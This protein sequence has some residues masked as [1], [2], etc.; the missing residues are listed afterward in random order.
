MSYKF[1]GAP[2]F[3]PN[4]AE[5]V[6][7]I[8]KLILQKAVRA[9]AHPADF[10]EF[11]MREQTTTRR[12]KCAPHQRIGL[13]F[14]LDH[15]KCVMVWPAGAAKTM[16]V[17]ALILWMLG[18][19][20]TK[21]GAIVSKTQDQA[22]KI[23]GVIQQYI[24]KSSELRLVFPHLRRSAN[25]SWREDRIVVDRPGAIPDASVLAIGVDGSIQGSR[26]DWMVFDDILDK[27][28]TRTHEARQK[29][30]DDVLALVPRIEA[31]GRMIVN[32][33][34]WHPEDAVHFL[35][36]PRKG[37]LPSLR[38]TITGDIY[39]SDDPER[40]RQGLQP[41]DHDLLRPK[42]SSGADYACRIKRDVPDL[43]NDI[44]LFPERF[45]YCD[46]VMADGQRLPPARDQKEAIERARWD[47]ENKRR[48]F[49]ATP[50]HFQKFYM[51]VARDDGTAFCQ[52]EWIDRCKEAARA[53]GHFEMISKYDGPN[54]TFTGVDLAFGLGEEHDDT[55]FFTFEVL[56][57]RTRKIL[58]I[59]SGKWN[60]ATVIQKTIRKHYDYNSV[61]RV[62][63]NAAQDAIRQGVIQ[64]DKSIPIKAHMTGRAK[65][66]PEHGVPGGFLEM[67]NA[68]WLIPNDVYGRVHPQV[69][70]WIDGCLYYAPAK[71]TDDRV[72]AWYF[73]REQAREWGLLAPLP[74]GQNGQASLGAGISG[75]MTR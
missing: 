16:T 50:G 75:I 68:G 72:M 4:D 12:I 54:P 55:A 21:R 7:A 59:E 8:Q 42:Y 43:H 20:V 63:S 31:G 44:P 6:E 41:W 74:K 60:V 26:L 69:Q 18:R 10:L 33:T 22:A 34:A 30:I 17:E 40:M 46:W 36:D 67:S 52:S 61:I 49:I 38:M 32:N 13:D 57:D 35:M 3:D 48:Q 62:E 5:H 56:P 66:H 27:D 37:G 51:G 39:I 45:Y 11:V 71:H 24:D 9:R 53:A 70:R 19:D 29:M 73:A 64:A 58:D 15:P 14:A 2:K 1:T 65:A 23:L 28:N 47:I 25:A